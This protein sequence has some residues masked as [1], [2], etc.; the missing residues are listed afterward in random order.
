MM[1]RQPSNKSRR[2]EIKEWAATRLGISTELNSDEIQFIT[3][4]LNLE[5]SEWYQL[6]TETEIKQDNEETA[7]LFFSLRLKRPLWK[8]FYSYE[9]IQDKKCNGLCC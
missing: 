4:R 1:K 6:M 5:K 7:W 8:N 3:D 2:E 9:E